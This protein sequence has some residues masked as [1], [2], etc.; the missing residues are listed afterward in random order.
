M[1]EWGEEGEKQTTNL[2]II[3]IN[4]IKSRMY[5]FYNWT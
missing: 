2:Q 1:N 5:T 4:V 3:I